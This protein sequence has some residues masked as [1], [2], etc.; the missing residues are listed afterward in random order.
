[1]DLLIETKLAPP[2]L[3]EPSVER[4]SALDQLQRAQSSQAAF[5]LAPA[6]YGK[7][8]LLA[9]WYR[10][11]TSEGLRTAWV[12]LEEEEADLDVFLLYVLTALGQPAATTNAGP[13]SRRAAVARIIA[14]TLDDERRTVLFLD[15]FHRLGG[16][17]DDLLR[18]L[19]DRATPRLQ[20]VVASRVM[21][22]IGLAELRSKG[23][24]LIISSD[25]LRM[26]FQEAQQLMSR[27]EDAS[28]LTSGDIALLLQRTEG[29]P[30][31][32]RM[33]SHFINSNGNVTSV[34]TG[35]SGRTVD[36][37]NYLY[38]SVLRTLSPDEQSVLMQIAVLPRICGDLI[39]AL[40]GRHDGGAVLQALSQRNV[41]MSRLDAEGQWYRIH[42]LLT[43]FL[44]QQLTR[45]DV[46]Q[47]HTLLRRAA[48]WLADAQLLPE[49]LQAAGS[50]VDRG[51]LAGI[52]DRAGGWR[53]V[54]DGRIGLLRSAL[55]LVP[56]E[57]LLCYPRLALARALLLVKSASTRQ[58]GVWFERIRTAS[59]QFANAL[60]SE[61]A[62]YDGDRL[63]TEAQALHVVLAWYLDDV[64]AGGFSTELQRVRQRL[65]PMVDPHLAG[66]IDN[67][68][69]YEEQCQRR[70]AA[71][72]AACEAALASLGA[73][74]LAYN[75]HMV[76][77]LV[78]GVALEQGRVGEARRLLT[79]A[80]DDAEQR[81][82]AGGDLTAS[83][84]VLLARVAVL[85]ADAAGD[86]EQLEQ[87]LSQVEEHDAWFELIWAG[88]YA[89]AAMCW[90]VG[91]GEGALEVVER[92]R[93]LVHRR[94]LARLSARLDLLRI[95]L[96]L[97]LKRH[98]QAGFEL[99]EPGLSTLIDRHAR[100]DRRIADAARLLRLRSAAP[101]A[102][103]ATALSAAV[104]EWSAEGSIVQAVEGALALVI[105]LSRRGLGSRAE[106][107]VELERAL[108][109]A[110]P[111]G[112]VLP[113][114]EAGEELC[115]L[116]VEVLV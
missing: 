100:V 47:V 103:T 49:A 3:T 75:A 43:E 80:H 84:Y 17:L 71:A 64:P 40:T 56:D 72:L 92:G 60:S 107:H 65:D 116:L 70:Y 68:L 83:A 90:L 99:Q 57:V 85:Q 73:A 50:L 19:I 58:A 24:V 16:A 74:G 29:W 88:Y 96:L 79:Q 13:T 41:L 28:Q 69:A 14:A 5:V 20:I 102:D 77:M 10:K 38:E 110:V 81:F 26:G 32:L 112:L 21:P 113:F 27:G 18:T 9:Q 86:R 33:A 104:S 61:S 55:P 115:D 63:L 109:W 97:R 31:A 1:M 7:T 98:A 45:H 62:G 95:E 111:G 4:R 91:D 46:E 114:L 105:M 37:A 25:Q 53:L 42:P 48:L 36:F 106:V 66:V 108:G 54:L 22:A 23:E 30:I 82:G 76:Q 35:F 11:C 2:T 93:R 39:N 87:S 34:L 52:L 8:E 94:G 6:G 51:V 44:V 15:D 12:S 101:C 89:L 59:N 78:A 67:L